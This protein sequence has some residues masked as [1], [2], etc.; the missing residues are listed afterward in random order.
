MT[1]YRLRTRRVWLAENTGWDW[2]KVDEAIKRLA[3]LSKE[4]MRQT[5]DDSSLPSTCAI[6]KRRFIIPVETSCK[7]YF[8][9]HCAEQQHLDNHKCFECGK[10]TDGLFKAAH[11]LALKMEREVLTFATC[12]SSPEQ[13]M[14]AIKEHQK[15]DA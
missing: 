10:P 6:C 12:I 14:E 7:H 13:A 3:A 5:Y 11:Y 8:C 4:K 2:E 1:R 9:S 15:A